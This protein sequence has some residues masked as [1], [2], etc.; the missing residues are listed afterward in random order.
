[1]NAESQ[2][3]YSRQQKAH[4]LEVAREGKKHCRLAKGE[5]AF[6]VYPIY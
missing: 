5:T 1:M 6:C 3:I 4:C 2:M